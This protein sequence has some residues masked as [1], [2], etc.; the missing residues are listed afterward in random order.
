[1]PPPVTFLFCFFG[2]LPSVSAFLCT[3]FIS[4]ASCFVHVNAGVPVSVPGA[5]AAHIT[6]MALLDVEGIKDASIF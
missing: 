5:V 1:M 4:F 3:L 6:S 2:H